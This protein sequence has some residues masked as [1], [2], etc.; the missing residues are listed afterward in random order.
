VQVHYR[1]HKSPPL[2]LILSQINSVY[3]IPSYL[4]SILI[5]FTHLRLGLLVV[6][7]FLASHQYPLCSHLHPH[8]CYMP[9]NLILLYF[10]ILIILGEEYKLWS[11]SLC[12]F[13]QPP[14]THSLFGPNILLST[15]FSNALSLCSSLNVSD[16]NHW[17]NNTFV[18]SIFYVF[19]QQTGRQRF[20]TEW[21]WFV[22]V[23]PKYLNYAIF[24]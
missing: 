1:V 17:Q 22:I 13:L 18:Y 14:L 2:V 11:S 15:L 7:F 20:W 19:R 6:S 16:Q 24:S 12:S 8:S 9:A 4:R 3:T 10:I 21:F 5:L 23:V